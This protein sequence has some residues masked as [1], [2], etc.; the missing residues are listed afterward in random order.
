VR[1][2]G[3]LTRGARRQPA[4]FRFSA[5]LA[6]AGLAVSRDGRAVLRTADAAAAEDDGGGGGGGGRGPIR[7]VFLEPR[8]RAAD[9]DG[10]YVELE[11]EALPPHP[12]R[13]RPARGE[14]G[15][16]AVIVGVT[17]LRLRPSG[18]SGVKP[19]TR[20]YSAHALAHAARRVGGGGGEGRGAGGGPEE[21]AEEAEAE[22]LRVGDRVGLLVRAGRL[23]AM[24]NGVLVPLG[25]GGGG[26]GGDSASECEEEGELPAL[27]RFVVEL[28][29]PWSRLRVVAGAAPPPPP[30]PGGGAAA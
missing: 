11:V 1:A 12:G 22:G 19:G 18:D 17:A 8:F 4:D 29:G 27:L 14:R 25:G 13:G 9:P 3:R 21:E 24:V 30:P 28:G 20:V 7:G 15:E 26:S 5:R 23:S 2:G 16:R 6:A 10:S